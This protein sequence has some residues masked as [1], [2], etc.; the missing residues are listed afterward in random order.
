MKVKQIITIVENITKARQDLQILHE[1]TYGEMVWPYM[2][3][4]RR[5]M[6]QEQVTELEAFQLLTKE[7][8]TQVNPERQHWL[9]AAVAE[10]NAS[11]LR[12]IT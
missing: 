4:L 10:I 12:K 8:D 6:R 5:K 1:K 11:E 9:M 3:E 7:E 2:Q